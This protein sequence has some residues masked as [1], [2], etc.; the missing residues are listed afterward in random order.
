VPPY[1]KLLYLLPNQTLIR[2]QG[3]AIGAI[4]VV[5]I[6]LHRFGD[7]GVPLLET[8]QRIGV[9]DRVFFAF[10]GENN[11]GVLQDGTGD[12]TLEYLFGLLFR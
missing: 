5:K 7:G 8:Y 10:G 3:G 1:R 6:D 4:H 11:S 12:L 9:N 2:R